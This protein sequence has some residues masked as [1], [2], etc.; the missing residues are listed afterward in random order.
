RL[1]LYFQQT[2]LAVIEWDT[3]FQVEDWN[4]AAE[5]IFGYA[6]A[7]AMGRHAMDLILP[8]YT[9]PHVAQIWETLLAGLGGFR[10]ANENLTK[11]GRTIYCEWYNTPLVA[12]DGRIIGVASLVQ[13]VTEQKLAAERISFLAYY[14]DLTG[15]PK[16][17]LFKDRLSQ[18]FID[19]DRKDRIVGIMF[20]DID[21][22]KVVNDTLGHAAGD[23][24]LPAVAKRLM[25]CFRSGD[26]VARFGGDE[27]AVI[28]ADVGHVDDVMQVAQH[29]VDG[30][31]EPFEILGHELF[32]T[33]SMG[34]TLYPFDD[35][36]VEN[37]LRNVDSAMYAAK[38]AGR[39][40][41]R[42]YAAAMTERVTQHL[43]LQTGLR[44][45]LDKREFVLHYQP[46]LEFQSN[47][48][49]GVE[50][51]LRWQD[52]DKG[53]ISPGQFIPV[54]EETGL[55][56]PIGEWVLHAACLQAKAWQEQGLPHVRMAVNLSA[57]QFKAPLFPARVLEILNQT[58][59][60]P[61]YLELEVTE[62]VLV[63][64]LESVSAVLKS[65]KQAGIMIS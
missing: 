21:D 24:L 6:K 58:G 53:T 46:Q 37:L 45:A 26:T 40:C 23:L 22:F 48:I 29:V 62:S 1:S 16:R 42:F 47:R 3:N 56:V 49:T 36:N 14:D 4:P 61:R 13:D 28:L 51:L 43:A 55:I 54:A 39:N 12:T 19:A 50:A 52:P 10:S 35:G 17:A 11:D 34:I 32:V 27:F 59:L 20:M 64:G 63:D 44:R 7:E 9:K 65:F 41:Y 30:F 33:F 31:R 8:E 60:D 25:G 2:P 5:K 38:A 18:A 15:L 57:R